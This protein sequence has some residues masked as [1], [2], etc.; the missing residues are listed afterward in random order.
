MASSLDSFVLEVELR[1][2]RGNRGI[3]KLSCLDYEEWN[4]ALLNMG[5]ADWV[6]PGEQQVAL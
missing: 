6:A 5:V 4:I 1:K 3:M 2:C